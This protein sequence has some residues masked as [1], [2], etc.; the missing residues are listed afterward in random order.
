MCS[1]S[2]TLDIYSAFQRTTICCCLHKYIKISLHTT[3]VLK[4]VYKKTLLHLL[5]FFL[6]FIKYSIYHYD[7]RL[8]CLNID[9][10]LHQLN[11]R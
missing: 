8:I 10:A 11:G 2:L 3:R 4:K 5:I 9:T 7:L 1:G 6:I